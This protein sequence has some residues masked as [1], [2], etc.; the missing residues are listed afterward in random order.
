MRSPASSCC[1]CCSVRAGSWLSPRSPFSRFISRCR[2]AAAVVSPTWPGLRRTSR[3]NASTGTGGVR[4]DPAISDRRASRHRCSPARD[5]FPAHDGLILIGA[6]AW[7]A[8]LF[9]RP[10]RASRSRIGVA[11]IGLG[12]ALILLSPRSRRRP[13]PRG[14]A[15]TALGAILPVVGDAAALVGIANLVHGACCSPGP[16]PSGAWRP[17]TTSRNRSS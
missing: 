14:T 16:H 6:F 1:R 9:G 15:A 13:A 8:G 17:P 11:C 3:P 10:P 5:I 2:V 4:R 12:V 7:R